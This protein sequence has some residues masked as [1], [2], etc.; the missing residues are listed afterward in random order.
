MQLRFSEDVDFIEVIGEQNLIEHAFTVSG[1][2]VESTGP[3]RDRQGEYVAYEWTLRVV[4][5]SDE[6]VTISPVVGLECDEPGAVCTIDDRPL[7][8]ATAVTGPSNRAVAVGGRG[9][10]GRRTGC[11]AGVRGHAD[12]GG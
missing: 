3:S 1:G 11:G 8:E 6:P 7:S 2:A 10:G 5:D 9:R 4:P 12:S